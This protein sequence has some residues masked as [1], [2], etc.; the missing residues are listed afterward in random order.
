MTGDD[1]QARVLQFLA[2]RAT[3]SG[4]AVT[5]HETHLSHVFLAGRRAWKLKK[6]VRLPF[7]DFSTLEARRVA[8]A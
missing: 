6:A 4:A 7:V 1:D 3:H 2:D 8:C 5:H